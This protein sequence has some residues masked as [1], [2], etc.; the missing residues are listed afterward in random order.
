MPTISV[1]I[2]PETYLDPRLH[3]AVTDSTASA[4]AT[5]GVAVTQPTAPPPLPSTSQASGAASAASATPVPTPTTPAKAA[6]PPR[7]S[8]TTREGALT[9]EEGRSSLRRSTDGDRTPRSGKVETRPLSSSRSPVSPLAS[10]GL[11]ERAAL[12]RERID[13]D[14]RAGWEAWERE[15]KRAEARERIDRDDRAGWEAWERE[16]DR[17]GR[18]LERKRSQEAVPRHY[19]P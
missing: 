14:D 8:T 11:R 18:I 1:V 19:F 5:A 13:R 3:A 4:A 9:N 17:A 6:T 15:K 7:P 16:K 2:K 10:P 12:E